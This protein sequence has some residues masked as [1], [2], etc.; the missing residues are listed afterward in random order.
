MRNY[1]QSQWLHFATTNKCYTAFLVCFY[2][3]QS[4]A[5][6][7]HY[8]CK[9]IVYVGSSQRSKSWHFHLHNT[10]TLF[11]FKC[12]L[13]TGKFPD[14]RAL[15]KIISPS[16]KAFSFSAVPSLNL[17]LNSIQAECHFCK[18][19]SFFFCPCNDIFNWWTLSTCNWLKFPCIVLNAWSCSSAC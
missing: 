4:T 15:F 7:H 19:K 9:I 12:N 3:Y 18:G 8:S 6:Q 5:K 14:L 11:K 13:L 1:W 16:L 2:S 10:C 17:K